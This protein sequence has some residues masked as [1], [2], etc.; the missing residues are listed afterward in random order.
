MTDVLLLVYLA[1]V[2]HNIKG[3]VVVLAIVGV[4]CGFM[5]GMFCLIESETPPKWFIKS[6]IGLGIITVLS[7]LIPSRTILHIAAGLRAGSEI[8]QTEQGKRAMK[9]LDAALDRAEESLEKK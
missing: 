2:L 9:L 1:D 8:A 3:L 5:F 6:M 4:V 7:T